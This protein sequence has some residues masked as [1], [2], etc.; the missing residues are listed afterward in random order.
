MSRKIHISQKTALPAENIR[1]AVD[2]VFADLAAT[3][4]LKGGW[5]EKSIFAIS[6]HGLSGTLSIG[7]SSVD[8]EITVCGVLSAF[9]PTIETNVRQKLRTHLSINSS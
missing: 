9:A 2:G 7:E 8:V 1:K 6:G 5:Q 3:Y 4:T